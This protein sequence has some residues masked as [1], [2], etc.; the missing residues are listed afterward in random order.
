[1]KTLPLEDLPRAVD[2]ARQ[3]H[4]A[5]VTRLVHPQ[6]YENVAEYRR[7]VA[8]LEEQIRPRAELRSE[9]TSQKGKSSPRASFMDVLIID[10]GSAGQ[11]HFEGT[12]CP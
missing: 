2:Y 4:D 9:A 5:G 6:G 12:Y 7:V 8:V 11:E 10:A 3:F 1:M